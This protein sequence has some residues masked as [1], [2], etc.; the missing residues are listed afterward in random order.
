MSQSAVPSKIDLG[1]TQTDRAQPPASEISHSGRRNSGSQPAWL[2]TIVGQSGLPC[3]LADELWFAISALGL[4]AQANSKQEQDTT[5]SLEVCKAVSDISP[6]R[7]ISWNQQSSAAARLEQSATLEPLCGPL[8][9]NFRSVAEWLRK[10]SEIQAESGGGA[11]EAEPTDEP[12]TIHEIAGAL[13]QPYRVRDGQVRLAG[14]TLD[15]FAHLRIGYFET[16]ESK[17]DCPQDS[18]ATL[19]YR[20]L[21]SNGVTVEEP[22]IRAMGF[23]NLQPVPRRLRAADHSGIETWV[24]IAC[25]SISAAQLS[26]AQ[27]I[28]RT[29]IWNRRAS[30]KIV[31]QFQNGRSVSIPFDG[32]ARNL[33]TTI[34]SPPMFHCPVTGLGS[35]NIVQLPDGTITVA[36]AIGV[37]EVSGEELLQR[38]LGRCE[39]TGKTVKTSLLEPCEI[40][41]QRALNDQLVKCTWCESL[42]VPGEIREGLCSR[43]A[44]RG[45]L[46]VNSPE[47]QQLITRN[48]T[49]GVEFARGGLS[50]WIGKNLGLLVVTS[51]VQQ[52]MF[53]V[54]TETGSVIRSGRRRRPFGKWQIHEGN[55]PAQH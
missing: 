36:E 15:E 17:N 38:D 5:L 39:L 14:C 20:F 52:R 53:V 7:T 3:E 9:L 44:G 25:E 2:Q 51:L 12:A 41:G 32:L 22:T 27:L 29:V 54:R 1:R 48:P 8:A 34:E 10:A 28:D 26:A 11:Y 42:V 33:A 49:L 30:G 16:G 24:R 50:G 18:N 37:C 46:E 19:H 13:L 40:T 23:A 21:S 55:L 47:I 4:T 35:Y 31:V 6:T 45:H 43:C